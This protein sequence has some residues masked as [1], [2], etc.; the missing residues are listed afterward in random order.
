MYPSGIILE[1]KRVYIFM[2]VYLCYAASTMITPNF[3][4]ILKQM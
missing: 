4:I 2:F 3:K 1:Q